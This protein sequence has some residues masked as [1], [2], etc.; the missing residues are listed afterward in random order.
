MQLDE[1]PPF[2]TI[3]RFSVQVVGESIKHPVDRVALRPIN[4]LIDFTEWRGLE[5]QRH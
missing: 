3:E 5:V 2:E 1:R 4:V